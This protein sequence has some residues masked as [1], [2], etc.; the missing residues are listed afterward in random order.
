MIKI[1][2]Q[3]EQEKAPANIF[4]KIGAWLNAYKN[5]V[6]DARV[7]TILEILLILKFEILLSAEFILLLIY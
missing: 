6:E 7:R 2:I 4:L 5:K 3:L 1:I